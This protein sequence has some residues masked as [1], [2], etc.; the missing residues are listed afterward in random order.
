[1]KAERRNAQFPALLALAAMALAMAVLNLP[2]VVRAQEG[3]A[4]VIDEDCEV[5]AIAPNNRIVY[6]V[7][8]MKRMKK[9]VIERDEIWIADGNRRRRIVDPDQFMP[10]PP[11]ATYI[12]K[13]L[14]WSPDGRHI[15]VSLTTKTFPWQ[16]KQ[17]GK[18]A[19]EDEDDSFDNQKPQ[20]GPMAGASIAIYMLDDDG[21][22]IPVPGSKD[23][24]IQPGEKATWLAADNTLVYVTP[25]KPYTIERVRVPN[26]PPTPLFAGFTFDAVVWDA[27][28]NRA[29]AV[30]QSLSVFGKTQ[31]TELDLLNER[32]RPIAPLDG[33]QGGLNVSPSGNKVGFFEDGDTI[34]ILDLAK[35]DNPV[36]VHTG[37]GRFEWSADER[38]ILLKRG[39]ED[40]SNDLVWVGLYDGS[41]VPALHDLRFHDFKI[42]PDGNSLAV[43]E[44]GKEVLKIYPLK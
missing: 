33:Y 9:L 13:S 7:P 5:F 20:V 22:E 38:R 44:P 37:P 6:A 40:E 43:T 42:T 35:P 24:F 18:H 14:A 30:G 16:P 26:G 28:R 39:P 29:F 15:A 36:Y 1:M 19:T 4:L 3:A 2:L 31:L 10:V 23:R 21:H 25:T 32:A 34:E 41:F 11:P 12:V 27:P 8:R 17:K